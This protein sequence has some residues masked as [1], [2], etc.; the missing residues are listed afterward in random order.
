MQKL[1][2]CRDIG[3]NCNFQARGRSEEEVLQRVSE[4]A[5]RAHNMKEISKEVVDKVRTA[6]YTSFWTTCYYFRGGLFLMYH[7]Y[8]GKAGP[9][10]GS[11]FLM[12]TFYRNHQVSKLGY[13][14]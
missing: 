5:K 2:K 10:K 4:H 13:T 1:F 11:P 3:T 6:I 12:I 9:E 14:E 7:S 8:L